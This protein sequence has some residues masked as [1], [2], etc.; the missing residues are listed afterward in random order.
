MFQTWLL[1]YELTDTIMILTEESINFLASKKKIEFLRKV[2]NQKTEE[3]EVPPVKLLVRDRVCIY[4]IIY[5]R[6]C[7]KTSC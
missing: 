5:N 4:H 2:E 6:A 3:T 1:S 7:A